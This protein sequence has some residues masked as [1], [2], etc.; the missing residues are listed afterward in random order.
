MLLMVVKTGGISFHNMALRVL[1]AVLLGLT[2]LLQ[3]R[4]WVGEGSV[5]EAWSLRQAVEN[6]QRQN[7][8]L[9]MR[10]QA[11]EAEVQ[12]LKQGMDAIEER[13][14]SELGM[15]REGETFY[16]IID[17]RGEFMQASVR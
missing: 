5:A 3:Y 4:L 1:I 10:N 7:L 11:L 15:I 13:A 16:Q 17:S 14:R 9:R 12:D 2:L 6:Q 8:A